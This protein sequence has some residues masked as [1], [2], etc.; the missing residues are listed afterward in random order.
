MVDSNATRGSWL[1]KACFT[2]SDNTMDFDEK[3]LR[4]EH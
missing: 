1:L 3:Q 2:L 4:V